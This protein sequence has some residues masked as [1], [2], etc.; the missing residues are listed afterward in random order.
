M[1]KFAETYEITDYIKEL[2]KDNKF[3]SYKEGFEDNL[4][5][6]YICYDTNDTHV[7]RVLSNINEDYDYEEGSYVVEEN[8][9][10]NF[11]IPEM[12]MKLFRTPEKIIYTKF[13]ISEYLN[14][15][16]SKQFVEAVIT[17][18]DK[19]GME[20]WDSCQYDNMGECLEVIDNGFG[21]TKFDKE[22]I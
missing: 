15:V 19:A 2:I 10:S 14:K 6:V 11:D 7:L 22:V 9:I 1:L 20:N 8:R 3:P 18:D 17:I 12:L 16:A 4:K 5:K 21:T 13:G